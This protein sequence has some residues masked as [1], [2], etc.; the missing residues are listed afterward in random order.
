MKAG[1]CQE[2]IAA[3]PSALRGPGEYLPTPGYIGSL[4]E[5]SRSEGGQQPPGVTELRLRSIR[6]QNGRRL[7][8]L[9]L[10][11]EIEVLSLIAEGKSNQEISAQLSVALNTVKRHAYHIYA[12]LG[13]KKRTQA[14]VRARQLGLIA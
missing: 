1:R 2:L 11:R 13:V 14:V 10:C 3:S 8:D 4:L 7:F 5:A 12:K 6:C 9:P